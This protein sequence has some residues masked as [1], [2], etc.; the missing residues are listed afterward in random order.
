M[1]CSNCR[2]RTEL[3]RYW[4]DAS[5]GGK[6]QISL[7]SQRL[8]LDA[9]ADIVGLLIRLLSNWVASPP[10]GWNAEGWI[11]YL[12]EGESRSEANPPH[13][14]PLCYCLDQAE[15]LFQD[16]KP[17]RPHPMSTGSP[18][19]CTACPPPARDVPSC[20]HH[21]PGIGLVTLPTL[22]QTIHSYSSC[23]P[24]LGY[25]PWGLLSDCQFFQAEAMPALHFLFFPH[26]LTQAFSMGSFL[27]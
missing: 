17:H 26:T 10:R 6:Q 20:S 7:S 21:G 15:W 5:G 23:S 1:G 3:Q 27:S 4:Q 22:H 13:C 14:F 18:W 24:K 12:C 2:W 19:P 8:D 25:F 11:V 9:G 16:A